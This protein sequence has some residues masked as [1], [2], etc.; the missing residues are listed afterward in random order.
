MIEVSKLTKIY[1]TLKAVDNISFTVNKGEILGFLG[2]NGAGKT[3]TMNMITGFIP[4]TDGDI[5]V[6]G[7]DIF[8][9]SKEVKKRI[10]YLP[11]NPPLYLD[12]TVTEYLNFVA[13]L[14]E[15]KK[16][17]RQTS[18]EDVVKKTG[19]TEM[20]K[21]LIK[22][23]SKGYR[24]R[25]GLAQALLGNPDVLILDEPTVGLDP[26][27]IIEIRELIKSLSKEHTVILSTHILPEVSM[28]C[29]RVVVINK[30]NIVA[31]DTP[32]NITK[33]VTGSTKLDIKV[34]GDKALII[35]V[36]KNIEN[37]LNV[38]VI[39]ESDEDI[40]VSVEYGHEL[41]LRK[42]ISMTLAKNNL[43][44]LEMKAT[45]LTLE[46]AFIELI[47]DRKVENKENVEQV[48]EQIEEQVEE[49]TEEQEEQVTDKES[50]E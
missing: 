4:M 8:E 17:E 2:P 31:V 7:L 13:E 19:L 24:Q 35:S 49:T 39:A 34:I 11:E 29:D 20:S 37:V 41:D 14:K 36:L 47:A 43:T 40:E 28:I 38:N 25:V 12:M 10:G 15:V 45:V 46:E 22:N 5:K 21:R 9:K 18:V 27:Q 6:C 23:L 33:N 44:V 32:E 3:T 30:G 42:E 26:K 48:E 1:G 50:E 16:Q